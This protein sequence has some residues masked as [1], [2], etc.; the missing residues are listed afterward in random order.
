MIYYRWS[1][2]D[3][4]VDPTVKPMVYQKNCQFCL[5]QHHINLY[6]LWIVRLLILVDCVNIEQT[7][8][9]QRLCLDWDTRSVVNNKNVSV[10]QK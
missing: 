4:A 9:E 3:S 5:T 10:Q 8:V 6:T 1:S 2:T 7:E